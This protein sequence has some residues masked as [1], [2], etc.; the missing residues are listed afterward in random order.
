MPT[1]SPS[2]VSP[3]AVELLQRIIRLKNRFKVVVP[4]NI[5]TLRNQFRESNLSGKGAGATD[6]GLFYSAGSVISG[7]DGPVSMGELSRELEVPLSTATR[8][9]DWLVNNGYAQRLPDPKD[10]RI[11][12]VELT[13][14]GKEAYR[15]M[16]TFMLAKV[17]Q[18][19]SQFTS[20][21]R[22]VFLSLL[23]KV[24]TAF[25]EADDRSA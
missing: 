13:D 6:G 3:E 19:M 2:P 9:V 7:H 23:N 17:E 18:A 1:S 12:L 24:L 22:E 21:E 4:E 15:A 8:T 10:R 16:S 5:A 20:G 25:E 11:V 14:S